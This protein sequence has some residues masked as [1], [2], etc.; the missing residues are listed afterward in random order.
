MLNSKEIS[1]RVGVSL[2]ANGF[3]ALIGFTTAM[4]L[5]RWLGPSEYGRVVFLLASHIA[6]RQFLDMG[7]S[8]AYFTFLSERA[9]SRY[10]ILIFWAWISLQFLLLFAL[11]AVILPEGI[12]DKI[13]N[14]EG[15]WLVILAMASGF[16]QGTVWQCAAQMGEAQR[17][18]AKV[19]LVGVLVLILHLCLLTIAWMT[20][21]LTINLIFMLSILEWG[22]ASYFVYKLYK[23]QDSIHATKP[24]ESENFLIIFQKYRYYCIPLI[25]LAWL[26]S[27]HDFFDRWML[28]V[29]SG[30]EEQAYF[31]IAAQISSISLLA[32]TA[33]LRIFWKEISEAK[34]SGDYA[35]VGN[36]YQKT[37]KILFFCGAFLSG[38]LLPWASEILLLMAGNQYIE[39]VLTFSLM[40]F[41]PI[42]QCLGQITNT[43]FYATSNTFLLMIVNG[44]FLIIG[45]GFTYLVLAP[46]SMYISGY[47]LGSTGLALK[48]I[49]M[50]LIFVNISMWMLSRKFKWPFEYSYQVWAILVC[51][52]V[53]QLGYALVNLH[54]FS[55]LFVVLK[56][57]GFCVIYLA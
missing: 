52:T 41:F 17:E 21:E 51:F 46:P 27:V 30:P 24:P 35:R 49:I 4:L 47:Q 13:W 43:M 28:Q 25:P 2:V 29:W 48:L 16:F 34:E 11:V 32:S 9:R 55:E 33:I 15:R 54:Y 53:S 5:A 22:I 20:D 19:Q 3:R 38:G 10:F 1:T 26:G 7:T 31:G 56:V 45:M 6:I 57:G 12:V 50:Q 23:T 37:S 40:L 44:F 36:L 42:H 39:G 14:G 18:T 8:S